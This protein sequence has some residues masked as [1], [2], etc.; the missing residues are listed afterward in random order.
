[1]CSLDEALTGKLGVAW[2]GRGVLC[3]SLLSPMLSGNT[4]ARAHTR[5]T[6]RVHRT[7]KHIWLTTSRFGWVS[8]TKR[9]LQM[10]QLRRLNGSC[11]NDYRTGFSCKGVAFPKWKNP[12]SI[13]CRHVG[14]GR[15]QANTTPTIDSNTYCS[16]LTVASTS[17]LV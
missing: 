10:K 8:Q 6:T 15:K 5:P 13:Y 17:T 12:T 11:V 16:A 9:C 14:P 3:Q 7:K 4:Q 1:M 2:L